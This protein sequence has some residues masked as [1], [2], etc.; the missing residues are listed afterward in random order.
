MPLEF[1]VTEPLE[2]LIQKRAAF[3]VNNQQ[4]RDPAKWYDGLY[5]L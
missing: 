2:N 1:F 5:R 3:I 4:H